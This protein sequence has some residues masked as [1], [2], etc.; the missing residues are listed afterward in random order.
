MGND[1]RR[2]R[3]RCARFVAFCEEHDMHDDA[4]VIVVVGGVPTEVE[5]NP[6]AALESVVEK[7][8]KQTKNVGQ[9]KENWELKDAAG[10]PLDPQSKV[11]IYLAA[12]AKV[13]LNLKA[14]IGG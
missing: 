5:A 10:N 3:R 4:K 1:G 11:A 8:L 13:Y 2:R 14:G 9:P 7:A 12:H 6:N